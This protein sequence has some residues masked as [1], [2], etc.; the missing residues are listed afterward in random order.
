[1]FQREPPLLPNATDSITEAPP[2]LNW[3][4]VRYGKS[5]GKSILVITKVF[6]VE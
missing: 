4:S 6:V 2:V 3:L 5:S 1:M